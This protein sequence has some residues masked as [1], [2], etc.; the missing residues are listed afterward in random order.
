MRG[1]RRPAA[2]RVPL[3][4]RYTTRIRGAARRDTGPPLRKPMAAPR[5]AMNGGVPSQPPTRS[6]PAKPRFL[7]VQIDQEFAPLN[8]K[9]TKLKLILPVV[10]GSARRHRS[11][12]PS[13]QTAPTTIWISSARKRLRFHFRHNVP[14]SCTLR[15]FSPGPLLDD[16]LR[17]A[18]RLDQ[19]G[20]ATAGRRAETRALFGRLLSLR[21]VPPHL[22]QGRRRSARVQRGGASPNSPNAVWS[23]CRDLPPHTHT[24]RRWSYSAACGDWR[25]C[26][27]CR[28]E[29]TRG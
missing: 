10:G 9:Q 28:Y 25:R 19:A 17:R 11:R 21:P 3:T 27:A 8:V 2:R 24:R 15:P 13:Q 14:A 29:Q 7:R 4:T 5:N 22:P 20:P 16:G 18:P 26:T 23:F 6:P 12:R 1:R